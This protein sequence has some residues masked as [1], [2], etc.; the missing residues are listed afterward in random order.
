MSDYILSCCSPVDVPL[1]SLEARDIHVLFFNVELGGTQLKDDFGKSMPPAELYRRMLAG[2]SAKTSQVSIGQ[3]IESW[4]PILKKG[5]DIVHVCLSS[6]IS[7]TYWSACSAAAELAERYPE[8][9]VSVVDSLCASAGYGMLVDAMADKRDEGLSAR[10]LVSWAEQHRLEIQHWFFTTDLTFFIRGGRVSKAAGFAAGVL[11]ICP[12]LHVDVK[13]SLEPVE[14]VRTKR[15]VIVRQVEKM[16]ELAQGGT[17]YDGKVFISNS[18]C[19]GD[20][21]AVAALIGEKFPHIN[22]PVRISDI[23]ATIGCHTGPGTVALF[24]WGTPRA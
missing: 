14:K 18:D 3:Y 13:G 10:E 17:N 24:F 5:L 22:G 11:S 20:A 23:G 8:R 6:G 2:E 9:T 1:E 19:A 16:V 7:G 21:Q 4:E 12:L 15:K